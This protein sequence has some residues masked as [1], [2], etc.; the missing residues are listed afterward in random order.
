MGKG[1]GKRT[2]DTTATLSWLKFRAD[3]YVSSRAAAYLR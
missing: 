3:F 1:L 2:V